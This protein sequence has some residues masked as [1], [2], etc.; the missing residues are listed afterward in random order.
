[1]LAGLA[2]GV[3]GALARNALDTSVKSP[4]QLRVVADAPN[5]GVLAF[6]A[7]V[8]K[9]PLTV[10][11]DPQSPRS[12]AFRQLR[13]NLQFLDVDTPHKVVAVTSSM[14]REGKTTTLANLAIALGSTGQR[15][16]AIEADLRRPKLADMLGLERSVGLTSVLSGRVPPDHAIQHWSGGRFKYLFGVDL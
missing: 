11:E 10:H 14:P 5:L 8:P 13:T 4:D 9:R 2:V 3:G 7:A 15:V 1:M 6:D 12:E 16:L